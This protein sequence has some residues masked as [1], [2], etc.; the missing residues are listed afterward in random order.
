[1]VTK[2]NTYQKSYRFESHNHKKH[3]RSTQ[4]KLKKLTKRPYF[5]PFV[6]FSTILVEQPSVTSNG[7]TFRST[8]YDY[9]RAVTRHYRIVN[10]LNGGKNSPFLKTMMMI[11]KPIIGA[12]KKK[13][14]IR[15]LLD[16]WSNLTIFVA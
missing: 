4:C 8:N 2:E 1:M 16:R 3:L 9:R 13:V 14:V 10:P 12:S 11:W 5:P 15:D 6:R 7:S